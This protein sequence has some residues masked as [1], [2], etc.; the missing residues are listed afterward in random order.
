LPAVNYPI[1]GNALGLVTADLDG[2]GTPDLVTTGPSSVIVLLGNGD[3]TFR[4]GGSY[5]VDPGATTLAVGDLNGDGIP[6]IIVGGAYG[7][8]DVLLGNGDGSFQ[9][10]VSYAV[11]G[12]ASSIA[13][14]DVNGDGHADLITADGTADLVSIFLGNGD[15]TFEAPVSYAAGSLPRAVMVGDF[16]G[17]RHVDIAVADEAGLGGASGVSVLLGNGDGTFQQPVFYATGPFPDAL[18]LGDF[19]G[20]GILDLVTVNGGNNTV[21]VLLGNGDGSFQPAYQVAAGIRGV[22]VAVADFTGT[23]RQD[24]AIAGFNGTGGE[25]SGVTVLLGN[26]DGTFQAPLLY[27]TDQGSNAVAVG[28]FNGDGYPDLAVANLHQLLDQRNGDVSVLLNAADW[29][30]PEALVR[31]PSLAPIAAAAP[32]LEDPVIGQPVGCPIME[33]SADGDAP[34][35]GGAIPAAA[36]QFGI[37][38]APDGETEATIPFVVTRPDH[39]PDVISVPLAEPV[40]AGTGLLPA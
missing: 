40:L 2:D 16:R 34:A 28:D 10:A 24:L 23:G 1:D 5:P 4:P 26:G 18:A 21:S 9:T 15:G 6:D 17:D 25:D 38:V 30:A 27:R 3:G 22:S 37:P 12:Y 33:Q 14:A 8:I 11:P 39:F 35:R 20:N 32:P 7:R 29:S 13:V 19:R 36:F 31:Q